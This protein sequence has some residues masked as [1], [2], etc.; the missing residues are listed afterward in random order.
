LIFNGKIKLNRGRNNLSM[1]GL[2]TIGLLTVAGTECPVLF[3]IF[4][5][6]HIFSIRSLKNIR[7]NSEKHGYSLEFLLM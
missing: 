5:I 1:A 7:K 2:I 3:R 6:L 4:S